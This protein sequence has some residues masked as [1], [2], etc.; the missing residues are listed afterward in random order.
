VT[1]KEKIVGSKKEK[2]HWF[3]CA[4]VVLAFFSGCLAPVK[5]TPFIHHSQTQRIFE[6]SLPK[7][8][9]GI[10]RSDL[11]FFPRALSN[12]SINSSPVGNRL[13]SN[14]E[15]KVLPSHSI[16][17]APVVILL[18]KMVGSKKKINSSVCIGYILH[19]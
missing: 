2:D 6:T 3:V 8:Q 19:V 15:N 5:E 16:S 9:E 11:Y 7:E 17:N 10:F 14:L 12:N 1:L 13:L 4:V 18:C